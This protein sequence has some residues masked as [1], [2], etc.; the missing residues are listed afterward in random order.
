MH[1]PGQQALGPRHLN[2]K[3]KR[4]TCTGDTFAAHR[5][6]AE[7][8]LTCARRAQYHFSAKLDQRTARLT[9]TRSQLLSR[10]SKLVARLDVKALKDGRGERI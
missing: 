5:T 6:V 9:H 7:G 8:G 2:L 1:H 10:G 4:V 3:E